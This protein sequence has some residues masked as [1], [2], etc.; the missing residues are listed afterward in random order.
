MIENITNDESKYG[1]YDNLNINK[2][3]LNIFYLNVGQADSTLITINGY[4]M[5]IDSGNASDGY[6]IVEFLKAQ[7]IDKIDYFILTHYDED[8]IGG[9]Y[10]ILEELEIGILYM[11]NN[12]S[13][14][15]TYQELLQSIEEN[16]I[17]SDTNLKASNETTYSLGE[18]YWKVLSS[19]NE[20][21]NINDSSIVI[22]L[23]YGDINY[24]FMGDATTKVEKNT[25][26]LWDEVTVLKVAHHGSD[27]STSQE[28]LDKIN[29]KYA[30]ISVRNR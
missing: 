17:N 11:P 18:A 26:I 2:E 5:L 8:H 4:T 24:L 9:A 14:T 20:A 10:K 28:F 25:D 29:P 15:D 30:I 1:E 16:N 23:Y 3:E 7:N 22:E 12:F 27:T 6:Y 19:D 13:T 21:T